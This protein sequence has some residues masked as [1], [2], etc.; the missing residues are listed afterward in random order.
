MP[1]T[2]IEILKETYDYYTSDVS[3][4]GLN[5]SGGCYYRI[6]V[7]G[8]T[9][10]CAVG[11]C[12]NENANFQCGAGIHSYAK[13]VND[14]DEDFKEEYRGHDISF[15]V[16]LQSFHDSE[17]NWDIDKISTEGERHYN[18]LVEKYT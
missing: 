2:K 15:W 12:F 14:L 11:R 7:D 13:G 9:K 16:D 10:M 1:K 18:L 8:I 6:I 5:S 4:R 17:S 3:R